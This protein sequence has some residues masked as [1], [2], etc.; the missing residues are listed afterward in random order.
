MSDNKTET[1]EEQQ[2]AIKYC[3]QN[4]SGGDRTYKKC[5]ESF[6]AGIEWQ[7]NL[8][9]SCEGWISVDDRLPICTDKGDW[10]GLK[11]EKVFVR[12][13]SGNYFESVL[14]SGIIDGN[15]FNDFYDSYGFEINDVTH[16]M[17]IADLLITNPSTVTPI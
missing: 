1:V 15:K 3:N 12:N 17:I 16:W 2:A 6:L 5:L 9:G 14:Y 11:S 8:S 13:K 10:D 7:K 4:H